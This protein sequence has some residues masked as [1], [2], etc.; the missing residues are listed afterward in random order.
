MTTVQ[1]IFLT[2]WLKNIYDKYVT[3]KPQPQSNQ[4]MTTTIK[5]N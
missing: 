1:L 3:K 5:I 4:L 2:K